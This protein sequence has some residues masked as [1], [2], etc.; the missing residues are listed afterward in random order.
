MIFTGSHNAEHPSV[1]VLIG[2]QNPKPWERRHE[3]LERTCIVGEIEV[4]HLLLDH[5]RCGGEHHH[6][7]EQAGDVHPDGHVSNHAL[8]DFPLPMRISFCWQ[9]PKQQPQLVQLS[10]GPEGHKNPYTKESG[11]EYRD[12]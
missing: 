2:S 10:L 11:R 5:I 12:L 3:A 8:K 1:R 4:H 6:L 7:R 9:L